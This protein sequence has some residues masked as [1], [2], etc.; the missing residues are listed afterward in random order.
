M[1]SYIFINCQETVDKRRQDE[2]TFMQNRRQIAESNIQPKWNPS[3]FQGT[4]FSDYNA[5]FAKYH[6]KSL[7]PLD[8]KPL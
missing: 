6:K 8:Q 4:E 1:Y 5:D 3:S 2:L 7:F